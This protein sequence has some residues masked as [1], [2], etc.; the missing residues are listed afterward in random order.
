MIQFKD[1]AHLYFGCEVAG[2]YNDAFGS[3][4]YLTGLTNGGVDC[5]IQFFLEDGINVE[6]EPHFNSI[7]EVKPILRPLSDL[8]KS[9]WLEVVRL[10]HFTDDKI[11]EIKQFTRGL[12]FNSHCYGVRFDSGNL[13]YEITHQNGCRFNYSNEKGSLPISKPFEL[14]A[15]LLK[16]GFD[17][18]DLIKSGQ[19]IDK[20]NHITTIKAIGFTD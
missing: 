14:T 19:A 15:Y 17:L 1:V 5:E 8:T 11:K 12:S 13:W 9:E 16:Q 7:E 20:T 10:C 2:T 4:G 18:F 3:I 6:E